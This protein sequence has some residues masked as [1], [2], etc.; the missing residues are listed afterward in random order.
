MAINLNITS[1]V[2]MLM[3]KFPECRDNDNTLIVKVW[4]EEKPTIKGKGYLLADFTIAF[5][6][7]EFSS[8]ETI[9]RTRQKLQEEFI[10][11]RGK[12]YGKRQKKS[13]IIKEQLTNPEFYPGGTP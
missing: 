1:T 12:S 10:E 11:L 3:E 7:G 9:R 2:K 4:A 13:T 6:H 8:T 5:K